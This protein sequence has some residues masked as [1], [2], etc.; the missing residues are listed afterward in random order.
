MD[1]GTIDDSSSAIQDKK[2][3]TEGA[4]EVT[5]K[6]GKVFIQKMGRALLINIL[7]GYMLLGVLGLWLTKITTQP[8]AKP[9]SIYEKR[10]GFADI[11]GKIVQPIT[12]AQF[13]RPTWA[14]LSASVGEEP[15][16][17]SMFIKRSVHAILTTNLTIQN[18]IFDFLRKNCSEPVILFLS[19][20]FLPLYFIF[21]FLIDIPLVC[22]YPTQ[23]VRPLLQNSNG[24]N[25]GHLIGLIG[26]VIAFFCLGGIVIAPFILFLIFMAQ[27]VFT[28]KPYFGD[29]FLGTLSSHSLYFLIIISWYLYHNC[30][31]YLGTQSSYACLLA[32]FISI[33]FHFVST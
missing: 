29:F 6:K 14:F 22:W 32:I 9:V 10:S 11:W 4:S 21:I 19:A 7:L 20:W 8:V 33:Y 1:N 5:M 15:N 18:S 3:A 24:L 13:S 28:S 12:M 25:M 23:F 27:N 26:L 16:S 30:A 31:L 2:D 17:F